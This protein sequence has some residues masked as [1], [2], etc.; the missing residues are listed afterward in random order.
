MLDLTGANLIGYLIRVTKDIMNRNPR[1][2]NTLGETT[3]AT[4]NQI[5]FG[6]VQ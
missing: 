2:R 1:F 6:D 3:F 5:N 4:N